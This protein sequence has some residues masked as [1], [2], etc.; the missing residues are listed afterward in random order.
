MIVINLSNS[1]ATR[2][3]KKSKKQKKKKAEDSPDDN[4]E[5]VDEVTVVVSV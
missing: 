1:H 2:K 5:A 4:L 3:K